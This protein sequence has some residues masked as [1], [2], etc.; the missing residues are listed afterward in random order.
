[1]RRYVQTVR[2]EV[3]QTKRQSTTRQ[4][5]ETITDLSVIE[6]MH[7]PGGKPDLT[8]AV[9][10]IKPTKP[11]KPVKKYKPI[12]DEFIAKRSPGSKTVLYRRAK[13]QPLYN[14]DDKLSR[15]HVV[16]HG[17]QDFSQS[18]HDF[19]IKAWQCVKQDPNQR[20]VNIHLR[21]LNEEP[22]YYYIKY[23]TLECEPTQT[24][25]LIDTKY[26]YVCPKCRSNEFV[27]SN[28]KDQTQSNIARKW[29]NADQYGY[30]CEQC[31]TISA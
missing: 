20:D 11:V 21:P 22:E 6:S 7:F 19:H 5:V 30:A 10:T 2:K 27:K 13:Q 9:K 17:E 28:L 8:D 23:I 29:R 3:K 25:Y 14:L 1:M 15:A 16:D 12:D 4:K 31:R 24:D 26:G 18:G